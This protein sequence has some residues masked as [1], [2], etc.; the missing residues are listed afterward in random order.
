[1]TRVHGSELRELVRPGR[2]VLVLQELQ[3]GVVGEGSAFPELARAA[4]TVGVIPASIRLA[5][6]ARGAQVPVIHATAENLPGGFG[7]NRNARLFE[8]ART[9]GAENLTGTV[10][11][12]PVPALYQPGDMVLPRYHGLSPL[13]GGPLDSLLRNAG[14]TTVV[15]AGV[16]LNVAIPN[17]AFDAVNRSYQVVIAADAVAGTPAEYGAEVLR[18]TLR[19]IATVT[20][21]DDIV[22]AWEPAVRLPSHLGQCPERQRPEHTLIE[23]PVQ[24]VVDPQQQMLPGRVSDERR[25][26]VW[27]GRDPA[28][29]QHAQH[30][31]VRR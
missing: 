4:A 13:T 8:L 14:V 30:C 15:L 11:V 29:I 10:S 3:N 23:P 12:Q 7:M 27:L 2:A 17:L 26:R 9:R 24:A 5:T 6:A 28:L 20:A 18:H 21:A 22:A 16:S 25:E 19:L 1:M 31:P